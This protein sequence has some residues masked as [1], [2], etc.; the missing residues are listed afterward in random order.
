MLLLFFTQVQEF[1][2][3]LSS[4]HLVQFTKFLSNLDFIWMVMQI[5]VEN[6]ANAAV[7]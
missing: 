4:A 6:M 7:I 1:I 3:K 2:A 5:I